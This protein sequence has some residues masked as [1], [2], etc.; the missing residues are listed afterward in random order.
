[1]SRMTKH[2][3]EPLQAAAFGLPVSS[4]NSPDSRT[5][6]KQYLLD[7]VVPVAAL[8]SMSVLTITMIVLVVTTVAHGGWLTPG[9]Y[10]SVDPWET[11]SPGPANLREDDIMYPEA[12]TGQGWQPGDPFSEPQ[13]RS[14]ADT[15]YFAAQLAE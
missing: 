7:T 14:A 13:A 5:L 12:A 2:V 15:G 11:L 4:V 6:F 1:M 10:M 8:L 9:T 3:V